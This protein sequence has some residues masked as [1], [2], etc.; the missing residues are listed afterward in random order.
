MQIPIGDRLLNTKRVKTWP[1]LSPTMHAQHNLLQTL[2]F[3]FRPGCKPF[4]LVTKHEQQAEWWQYD[5]SNTVETLL[6]WILSGLVVVMYGT[7]ARFLAGVN[8]WLEGTT[9]A[10][11]ES[12]LQ[13]KRMSGYIYILILPQMGR[14]RKQSSGH[15]SNKEIWKYE[16]DLLRSSKFLHILNHA[17]SWPFQGVATRLHLM[18]ASRSRRHRPYVAC[19]AGLIVVGRVGWIMVPKRKWWLTSTNSE[20]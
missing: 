20:A 9:S 8:T 5:Y 18:L 13:S 10:I 4:F 6:L 1:H 3:R 16:Q 14:T 17:G 7:I 15:H 19:S 11:E 2:A 12:I